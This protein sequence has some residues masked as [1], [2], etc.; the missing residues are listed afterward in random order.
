MCVGH[1]ASGVLQYVYMVKR[2]EEYSVLEEGSHETATGSHA[3][4]P[5]LSFLLERTGGMVRL[6]I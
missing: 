5:F 6:F 2:S 1:R 4:P 3:L